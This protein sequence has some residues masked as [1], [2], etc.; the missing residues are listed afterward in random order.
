MTRRLRTLLCTLALL[1]LTPITANAFRPVGLENC[2]QLL[3]PRGARPE[4]LINP[5]WIDERMGPGQG[6]A[7]VEDATDVITQ[8]DAVAGASVGPV[9]RVD[10][11]VVAED[12]QDSADLINTI[13]PARNSDNL[14]HAFVLAFAALE[15]DRISCQILAADAWMAPNS[16]MAPGI[17]EIYGEP[18]FDTNICL[19]GVGSNLVNPDQEERCGGVEHP[20]YFKPILLHEMLHTVGLGHEWDDYS[21]MNYNSLPW[22]NDREARQITPLPDD[23]EGLREFYPSRGWESDLSVTNTFINP[24]KTVGRDEP[25][26]SWIGAQERLCRPSTGARFAPGEWP[27]DLP[28]PLRALDVPEEIDVFAPVCGVTERGGM[29]SQVVCPGDPLFVAYV[30][31]NHG[32]IPSDFTEHLRFSRD[33]ELGMADMPSPSQFAGRADAER[34]HLETRVFEVPDLCPGV[35]HPLVVVDPG[36]AI[37]RETSAQNNWIPLRGTVE[38]SS[39]PACPISLLCGGIQVPSPWVP[40][41]ET[42]PL[43]PEEFDEISCDDLPAQI[44]GICPEPR[45]IPLD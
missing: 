44:F 27:D 8:I 34:S 18:Y 16:I 25:Q 24:A 7:W 22:T 23:R 6:A 33:T 30:V 11:T 20:A 10:P 15:F 1:S 28:E 43:R 5:D 31:S 29:G 14:F 37:H 3:W 39:F 12:V 21:F 2:D 26:L 19:D 13:S 4:F 9:L 42:D 41:P 17:P 36:D 35:Y 45:P 40:E 38:V 32:T